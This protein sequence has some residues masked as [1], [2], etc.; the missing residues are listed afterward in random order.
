[1]RVH[2][3]MHEPNVLFQMRLYST[4][5]SEE[6]KI[7]LTLEQQRRVILAEI[8]RARSNLVVR[9]SST[10]S[11][12][13]DID[14]IRLVNAR[15][16]KGKTPAEKREL[17][18]SPVFMSRFL[19]LFSPVADISPAYKAVIEYYHEKYQ[20][21]RAAG[22]RFTAMD[23]SST[24]VDPKL[25]PFGNAQASFVLKCEFLQDIS[26]VHQVCSRKL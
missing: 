16:L 3:L 12:H 17:R 18:E 23:L 15:A 14:K 11:D 5:T 20:A 7:D 6:W 1:M 25:S 19:Q 8:Q 4:P 22:S 26:T 21:A 13:D 2:P 9:E 10:T 24:T